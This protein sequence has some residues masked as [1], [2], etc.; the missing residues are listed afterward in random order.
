MRRYF[1]EIY[2]AVCHIINP[3]EFC[4][5]GTQ[6]VF[7]SPTTNGA[8]RLGRWGFVN[9]DQHMYLATSHV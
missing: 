5:T 2:M 4:H 9:G 6:D 8:R 7:K 3:N 1:P